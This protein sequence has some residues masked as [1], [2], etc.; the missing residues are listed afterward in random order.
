[1]YGDVTSSL[2]SSTRPF[3]LS[4][5][6]FT[7]SR[8][9]GVPAPAAIQL[10]DRGPGAAVPCG[11][12]GREA[13]GGR[14]EL[15]VINGTIEWVMPLWFQLT[16]E[17]CS[18]KSSWLPTNFSKNQMWWL[19][20]PRSQGAVGVW[21]GSSQI[22]WCSPKEKGATVGLIIVSELESDLFPFQ[23]SLRIQ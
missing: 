20:N 22:T 11:R 21:W 6:F 15:G 13:A 2:S 8:G 1:M 7:G 9:S 23:I 4:Q 16:S 5:A 17:L 3:P 10:G 18:D 12:W 19:V 14:Q